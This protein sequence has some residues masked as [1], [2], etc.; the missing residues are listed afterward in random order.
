MKELKVYVSDNE[1]LSVRQQC[2]LLDLSRSTV[3]YEAV[4]ESEENLRIM[5]LM[6][7][8]FY[9]EPTHGVLQMQDFLFALNFLVNHKRVRSLP[10]Y[11]QGIYV[12][13]GNH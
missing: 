9:A 8:E 11:G 13:N 12:L 3:Y 6:D 10:A 1:P 7:E 5:R 4:G 2:E